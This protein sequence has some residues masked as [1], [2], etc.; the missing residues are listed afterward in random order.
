MKRLNK[1][2]FGGEYRKYMDI[3]KEAEKDRVF[4]VHDMQHFLDVSR[5]LYIY[6]LEKGIKAD[7][8]LIYAAG[9]LH[10]I[11]R[12]WQYE[13]GEK[14]S[15][16]SVKI[17]SELMPKYG[18]TAAETE[19]VCTLISKHGDK[20]AGGMAALMYKAD[21]KARLCFECRAKAEC[22]WSEEKKNSEVEI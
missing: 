7:K 13:R 16:A 20:N 11:G 2:I 18:F 21:K 15:E 19:F 4:C 1:L 3:I 9:L 6:C 5:I 17:A 10:D 14:H 22:N 8:E 12:A